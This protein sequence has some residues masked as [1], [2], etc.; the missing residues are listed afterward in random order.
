VHGLRRLRIRMPEFGDQ[1]GC[2]RLR[3]RPIQ[4]PRM[5]RKIRYSTMRECV[6]NSEYLRAN[7]LNHNGGPEERA[8]AVTIV[9]T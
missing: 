8:I 1:R 6:P 4:V 5:Q 9:A 3:D 2:R 7:A